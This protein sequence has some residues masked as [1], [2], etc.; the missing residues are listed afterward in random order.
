M[1]YREDMEFSNL[2]IKKRMM[3][4]ILVPWENSLH[5]VSDLIPNAY[6]LSCYI[7]FICEIKIYK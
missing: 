4:V 5:D 1:F 6:F 2:K 7:E 3:C